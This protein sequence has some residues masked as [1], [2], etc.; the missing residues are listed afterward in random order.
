M[1]CLLFVYIVCVGVG[2]GGG[3]NMEECTE[4]DNK[5]FGNETLCVCA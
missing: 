5:W 2:G 3:S 4:R 1:K